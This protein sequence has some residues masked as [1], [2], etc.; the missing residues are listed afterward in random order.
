MMAR[1]TL[2]MSDPRQA[3]RA[4]IP[5]MNQ[6]ADCNAIQETGASPVATRLQ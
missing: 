1:E 5:E 2:A 3:I 4:A 6:S